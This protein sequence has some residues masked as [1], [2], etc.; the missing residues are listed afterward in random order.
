MGAMTVYC[1]LTNGFV[2]NGKSY[3]IPLLNHNTMNIVVNYIMITILAFIVFMK[4]E[5]QLNS[6]AD[7]KEYYIVEKK[8]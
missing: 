5:E 4:R 6:S 7:S 3:Y 8:D 1:M 2:T